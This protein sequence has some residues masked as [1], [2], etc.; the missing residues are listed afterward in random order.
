[1]NCTLTYNCTFLKLLRFLE[2]RDEHICIHMSIYI[3]YIYIYMYMY[4]YIYIYIYIYLY[5]IYIYI[6]MIVC[7]H[8]ITRAMQFAKTSF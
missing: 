7:D 3:I 1:M 5:Y 6:Y 4:I 8:E 2:Q